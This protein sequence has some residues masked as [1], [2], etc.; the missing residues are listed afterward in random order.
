MK[1]L[2]GNYTFAEY[3]YSCQ[4]VCQL[5]YVHAY[6]VREVMLFLHLT[7]NEYAFY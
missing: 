5:S 3:K 1:Y 2:P 6:S 4:V 7:L